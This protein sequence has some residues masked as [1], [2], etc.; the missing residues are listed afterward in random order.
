M[1]KKIYLPKSLSEMQALSKEKIESLWL[2]YFKEVPKKFHK[3]TFRTLWYKIQ[4]ENHNLKVDQKHVTRLNRY[5]N[6]PE[7]FISKSYKTK[8]HLRNGMEIIKTY[9]G[10]KY[11]VLVR[12]P[13]EFIYNNQ[14]YRTL[15]AAAKAICHIKVS[16]YDFFGLNN[17]TCHKNITRKEEECKG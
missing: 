9:K 3:M 7:T 1:R 2:R 17:K 4:C 10:R 11:K 8:Y 15:S 12:S 6:D 16:G 14:V 5:A 13:R